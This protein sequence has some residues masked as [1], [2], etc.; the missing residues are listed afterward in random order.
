MRQYVNDLENL[1]RLDQVMLLEYQS[2]LDDVKQAQSQEQLSEMG[3]SF[4]TKIK[5]LD[6]RSQELSKV[7]DMITQRIAAEDQG[8][9]GASK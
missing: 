7:K 4:S 5:Q 8:A 2:D 1:K 9:P 6:P 3:M